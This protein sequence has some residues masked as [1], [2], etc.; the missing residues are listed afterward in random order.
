MAV[1]VDCLKPRCVRGLEYCNPI[2][3]LDL[4][5][6]M[7]TP[8]ESA[9]VT[10]R[11]ADPND[12][13]DVPEY[14]IPNTAACHPDD[15]RLAFELHKQDL[16]PSLV[17]STGFFAEAGRASNVSCWDQEDKATLLEDR[18]YAADPSSL[19]VE[20][21]RGLRTSCGGIALAAPLLQYFFIVCPSIGSE[22]AGGGIECSDSKLD[23]PTAADL[24]SE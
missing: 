18:L 13:C 15:A 12:V 20:L 1:C 24:S 10:C 23:C 17:A 22:G 5:F 16:C 14:C 8:E 21:P 6:D 2:S 9:F 11:E 4:E 19:T 7:Y 3:G